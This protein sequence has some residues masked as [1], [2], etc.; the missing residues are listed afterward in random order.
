VKLIREEMV[1]VQGFSVFRSA[2]LNI[3]T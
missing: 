3:Q 1:S 2:R